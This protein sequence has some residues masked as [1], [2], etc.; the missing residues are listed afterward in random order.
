MFFN[1][2]LV[3]VCVRERER[4]RACTFKKGRDSSRGVSSLSILWAL[5][6]K[7]GYQAHH[8]LSCLTAQDS[9]LALFCIFF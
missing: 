5:G 3:Y 6:S 7:P 9:S 4:V 1:I 8:L 2:C